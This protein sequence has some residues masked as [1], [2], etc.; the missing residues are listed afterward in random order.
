MALPS[1][2][3]IMPAL[4]EEE[5]IGL[6][7]QNALRAMDDLSIQGEVLVVNDGSTDRTKALIEE[8][9]A[10]DARIRLLHHDRPQGIGASFWD[11]VGHARHEIVAMSPGDDENDPW[12]MLRYFHLTEHVDAVVPFIFN[13]SVRSRFRVFVSFLFRLIINM[14]F[15]TNF[16]YTNGA[17]MYRRSILLALNRRVSGFFYQT[18]ILVRI[19]NRGYL[20]AE[21]PASLGRRRSGKS[22]AVSFRSLRGVVA[23]FLSLFVDMYFGEER[24]KRGIIAKDTL[25]ERRRI[26]VDP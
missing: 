19:A 23:G 10:R 16:N 18:D 3:I 12:E 8:A 2:S 9:M 4:N 5:N 1:I 17:I 24:R 11:G 25:T 22:T 26:K 13:K 7:M 20:F 15:L 14:A 6:A 21:V